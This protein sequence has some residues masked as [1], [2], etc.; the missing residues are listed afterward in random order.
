MAGQGYASENM[1]TINKM[2]KGQLSVHVQR[3]PFFG[4]GSAP[5]VWSLAVKT[6]HAYRS[7]SAPWETLLTAHLEQGPVYSAALCQQARRALGQR[8]SQA[9][10]LLAELWGE[11]TLRWNGFQTLTEI[12][13]LVFDNRAQVQFHQLLFWEE[14]YGRNVSRFR[15]LQCLCKATFQHAPFAALSRTQLCNGLHKIQPQKMSGETWEGFL[16]RGSPWDRPFWES[17]C[18]S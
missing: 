4:G 9:L 8:P 12:L 18:L 11:P 16:R 13:T 14:S 5:S 17:P 15:W 3:A 7:L 2:F 1:G 10:K 6:A